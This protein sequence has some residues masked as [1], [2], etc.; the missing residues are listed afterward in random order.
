M[1]IANSCGTGVCFCIQ[2]FRWHL[3]IRILLQIHRCFFVFEAFGGNM[4]IAILL[5]SHS[6]FCISGFS[7]GN[8]RS[9][10]VSILTFLGNPRK[11]WKRKSS[12]VVGTAVSFS[13][14]PKSKHS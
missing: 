14:H 3:R 2:A 7:H 6:V 5:R 13:K 9:F 1:K 8:I 12:F 10:N 11:S 4:K